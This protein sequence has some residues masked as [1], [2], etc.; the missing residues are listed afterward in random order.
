V[1][2]ISNRLVLRSEGRRTVKDDLIVK[3]SLNY[4]IEPVNHLLAESR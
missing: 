1:V 4:S 2:F 3:S